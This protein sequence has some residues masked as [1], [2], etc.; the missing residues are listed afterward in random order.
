MRLLKRS[1]PVD[2]EVPEP[3][4]EDIAV[5]TVIGNPVFS[6]VHISQTLYMT[7]PDGG[8]V[9]STLT[10]APLFKVG[11]RFQSAMTGLK[12]ELIE[13]G[14]YTT[15]DKGYMWTVRCVAA[16]DNSHVKRGELVPTYE[17]TLAAD[18]EQISEAAE[19]PEKVK[20]EKAEEKPKD[21]EVAATTAPASTA[22]TAA[23]AAPKAG[24]E[25]KKK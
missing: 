18:F 14:D 17:A 7:G 22:P 13:A 15:D 2:I 1:E 10:P 21:G 25:E 20:K 23:K 12:V 4:L 5:A 11:D 16:G 3:V 8:L 24:K 19:K 6:D 9:K